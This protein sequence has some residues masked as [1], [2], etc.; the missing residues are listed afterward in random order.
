L[1]VLAVLPLVGGLLVF[2]GGYETNAEFA[3]VGG[4]K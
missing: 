3:S 1:L 2:L 4:V